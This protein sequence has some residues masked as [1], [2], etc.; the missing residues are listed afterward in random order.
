[1]NRGR[2]SPLDSFA[3]GTTPLAGRWMAYADLSH[4][5]PAEEKDPGDLDRRRACPH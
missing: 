3:G 4:P 2:Y 1:M 5:P